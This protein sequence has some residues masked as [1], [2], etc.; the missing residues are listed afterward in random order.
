[1]LR[2]RRLLAGP[3]R[4]AH[5]AELVVGAFALVMLAGTALLM[6]PAS[7]RGSGGAPV[8]TAL[9]TATSAVC[10]T[11][12]VVVDTPTYWSGFG[13]VVI[14]VLIQVGGFGIMTLASRLTLLLARRIGLGTR[15]ITQTETQSL[16]L[17]DLRR[18]GGGG[19]VVSAAFESA[20][21]AVI[22]RGLW[23]RL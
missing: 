11:G 4:P 14:L 23:V 16:H 1:M 12:L 18:G 9:F 15:L 13:Q 8:L 7:T 17:G 3:P 19:G 2:A 10:V 5:P 20:A 22:P 6:F 21:A